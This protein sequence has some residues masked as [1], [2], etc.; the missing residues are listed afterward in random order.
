MQTIFTDLRYLTIKQMPK[1]R[2]SSMVIPTIMDFRI[3][4]LLMAYS[5]AWQFISKK[6]NFILWVSFFLEI[7]DFKNWK[8]K[9][10]SHKIYWDNYFVQRFFPPPSFDQRWWICKSHWDHAVYELWTHNIDIGEWEELSLSFL[11]KTPYK[12]CFMEMCQNFCDC[13]WHREVI[14]AYKQF[15]SNIIL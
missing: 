3:F 10:N 7:F 2:F 13:L 1:Q 9:T 12:L 4:F 8:I 5:K 6:Y 11:I 15:R 14:K